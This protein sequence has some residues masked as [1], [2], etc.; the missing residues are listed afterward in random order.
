MEAT[1]AG[2]GPR[3]K[4]SGWGY[5][6]RRLEPATGLGLGLCPGPTGAV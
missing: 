2:A 5:T 4:S 1:V 6:G 3:I